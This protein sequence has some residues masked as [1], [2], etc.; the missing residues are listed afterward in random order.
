MKSKVKEVD[1]NDSGENHRAYFT[2]SCRNCAV[3]RRWDSRYNNSCIW[4]NKYMDFQTSIR[5]I[6]ISDVNQIGKGSILD[7]FPF[8][9]KIHGVL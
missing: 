5:S 3:I 7:P 2:N 9:R 8:S 6:D 1:V 4:R